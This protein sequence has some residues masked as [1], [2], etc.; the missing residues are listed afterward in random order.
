MARPSWFDQHRTQLGDWASRIEAFAAPYD[1]PVAYK[2]KI[3]RY[4]LWCLENGRDPAE[5][6]EAHIRQYLAVTA[7]LDGD[8]MAYGTKSTVQSAIRSWQ[9]AMPREAVIS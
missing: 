6:T 4:V 7:L 3:G 5:R 2:R 9:R 8:P 1:N